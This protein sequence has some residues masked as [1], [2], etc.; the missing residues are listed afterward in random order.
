MSGNRTFRYISGTSH[1]QGYDGD[2][3]IPSRLYRDPTFVLRLSFKFSG[4][5]EGT[6]TNL[7]EIIRS[8]PSE[9]SFFVD[10]NIWDTK[11]EDEIW[12]ALL[13]RRDSVYV[14]P[15]VR[16]ELDGWLRRNPDY[17][18]TRGVLD[19][20]STLVAMPFPSN[21]NE[22]RAYTYYVTLLQQRRRMLEFFAGEF[23]RR[24]G[25]VPTESETITGLQRTVGERGL[26][27]VRKHGKTTTLDRY[28]TDE[29]LVY[30]AAV[31]AVSTGRPTVVL[32]KDQDVLEQFYKLWWFLDTHYR[33][34]LLADEY[35]RDPLRYKLLPLPTTPGIR[36]AF[37]AENGFLVERG[38]DR[39]TAVLPR[40]FDF[41][42][43]ECWLLTSRGLSR[44]TFGAER[45]MY[46]LISTKGETG[47]RVSRELGG[48][49]LQPYLVPLELTPHQV[50][51]C[52]MIAKE[53]T[54]PTADSKV[55]ISLFDVWHV[56]NTMERRRRIVSAPEV[57]QS[58][59]WLPGERAA[60]DRP[61]HEM[62]GLSLGGSP[63]RNYRA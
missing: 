40:R 28:A 35:M 31:H 56:V 16:L 23:E 21:E 18:G 9:V 36:M 26:A 22:V 15:N 34:M 59:L 11:I 41:V 29:S 62:F 45:Q 42:S 1:K 47:G 44:A 63:S 27:L 30:F 52:F 57:R 8:V 20:D 53:R 7:A 61:A 19:D 14:I 54:A 12:H 13:S 50:A 4:P 5:S 38:V 51:N 58:S 48:R 2:Q 3:T 33:A 37:H 55:R 10:S 60:A 6:R 46:R 49:N 25:R 43:C 32:T 39:M 24:T 17:V